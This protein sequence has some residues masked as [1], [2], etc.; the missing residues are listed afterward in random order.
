MMRWLG[1]LLGIE[2]LES[3]QDVSLRFAAPWAQQ[4][5]VLVVFCCIAIGA[6]GAVFYLRFQGIR[7]KRGRVGMAVLRAALLALL[8]AL[9]AEPVVSL[10]VRHS[11]RSLLLV[12]FDGTES[13]NIS[14]DPSAK[15][16][17]PD[18]NGPT[19]L[20]LVRAAIKDD[21]DGENG[22]NG[23]NGGIS[24]KSILGK[25]GEKFRLRGYV[26]D[27][28]DRAREILMSRPDDDRIDG[29][30]V[31]EQLS[32]LANVTAIG[33]A[34]DDLRR[35]NRS[36]LLAG[37]VI[38]SDF[39]QNRGD[40]A[41]PAA[42]QLRAPVYAIGVGPREVVDLSVDLQTPLVLKKGEKAE[43][44]VLLRQS[45]L[46]GRDARIELLSRR[47][48]TLRGGAGQRSFTHVA[49]VQVVPLGKDMVA[50][51]IIYEPRQS[52]RFTLRANAPALD[53]EATDEN[54]AAE[55]EI[56]VRDESLKLLFVEY[57]P[58]WEWRFIKEVFHRHPMIGREGFRTYLESADFAVRGGKGIFLEA[59]VRPRA[60]FFSYD[61]ILLSDVP[62]KMLSPHVQEMIREYVAKFGGG[63]VVISGARFGPGAL[64]DTKLADMLPVIAESDQ[65]PRT[66]EFALQLTPQADLHEFMKLGRN[67][68]ENREAWAAFDKMQWYRPVVRPHPLAT[69]LAVHPKDRCVDGRT[70][71]PL[72][73]VRRYGKGQVVYFAF[74][75]MWRLRKMH[76]EKYYSQFWGQLI[77]RLGLGRALGSQK[78]FRLRTD[79][80]VY[81]AGQ[82][83]RITVEAYTRSYEPLGVEALSG[84]L[85]AVEGPGAAKDRQTRFTVPLARGEVI[86]ET[87]VP[88]FSTGLHRLLIEDPVTGNEMETTFKVAAASAER[89]STV[90]NVALQRA[91]AE[92]TGGRA[93]ELDQI[94]RLLDD[95]KPR[96]IVQYTRRR[97]PLWNTWL[98]LI[99]VLT[100]MVGEWTIRKLL[101][102]Q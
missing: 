74:N 68:E 71:Q 10:G 82:K 102:L 69:V 67:A 26:L 79:R 46:A 72:I 45:G 15:T 42:E 5:P 12:L 9:I 13:M 30:Y 23:G 44:T 85:I 95:V 29:N 6:V 56:V 99:L 57:E 101:N 7:G 66:D 18:A 34:L 73:A 50:A 47:M 77:Y 96:N 32:G 16:R 58:T 84:R 1:S 65:Y 78:R 61:V 48:G 60:E 49:P 22:G 80:H 36:H 25:L 17:Q 70:P 40:P 41:L 87:S 86:F 14:D 89:R 2:G 11:P 63:L 94:E 88:V 19:R 81:Q 97:I 8:L 59:L 62:G 64:N 91:M 93:Y 90:R 43:V 38:V 20:D 83:V 98:V 54:N 33:A 28:P 92:R 55:R 39:D 4:R 35:R 52:G 3:V 31:A 27:R 75:E 21:E 53:G 100:L 51:T 37:V 24:G 76:G